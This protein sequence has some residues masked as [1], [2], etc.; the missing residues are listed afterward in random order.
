MFIE[1]HLALLTKFTL[2]QEQANWVALKFDELNSPSD[3]YGGPSA[4]ISTEMPSNGIPSYCGTPRTEVTVQ[5]G[6]SLGKIRT[7]LQRKITLVSMPSSPYH[8]CPLATWKLQT[9]RMF[10]LD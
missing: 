1:A 4:S 9:D 8:S 6:M 2:P 3:I 5:L 7:I 10:V